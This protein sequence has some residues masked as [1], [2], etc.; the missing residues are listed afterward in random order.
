[1]LAT[2]ELQQPSNPGKMNL[3]NDLFGEDQQQTPEVTSLAV[4]MPQHPVVTTVTK[5][6]AP[7]LQDPFMSA[8]ANLNK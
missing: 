2:S 8:Q 5:P 4:A 6:K 1:M 3:L 7:L